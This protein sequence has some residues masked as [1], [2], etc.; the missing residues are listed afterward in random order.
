MLISGML[1]TRD[2]YTKEVYKNI[3]MVRLLLDQ[4]ANVNII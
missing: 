1:V 3:E 2:I 4:G